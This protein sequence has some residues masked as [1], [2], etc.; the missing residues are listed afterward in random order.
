M[1]YAWRCL[2][3]KMS[4]VV[5]IHQ[6]NFFPWLGYF[7]KI[8][9]SDTFIFLDDVQFPKTGG[10]WSN[11]VKLMVGREPRWASAPVV[12]NFHGVRRVNETEFQPN[13]PW[14]SKLLRTLA[15]NYAHAPFLDESMAL[16]T[17]LIGNTENNLSRYNCAAVMAIMKFLDLPT[18]KI[19]LASEFGV[20]AQANE[21][22]VALTRSV[23]ANV[24]MCGGGAENYQQE[25]VFQAAGIEL[26]HQKFTHPV[27]AQGV[28]GDFV[29]GLS[30]IDA[31]MN[32]GTKGVRRFL[33]TT[34]VEPEELL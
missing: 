19:R 26:I 16:L 28:N 31:L 11:R 9:R 4:K 20:D 6:P 17:P 25:E 33:C 12:R 18:E 15:A 1:F 27:Y 24:Y 21:M 14:R 13:D 34:A 32:V 2:K 29:P 8:V 23:D 5:A 30:I 3:K 7:D 22:L 10:G